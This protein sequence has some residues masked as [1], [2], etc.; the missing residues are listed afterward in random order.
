[1]FH[2]SSSAWPASGEPPLASSRKYR[3]EPPKI[4]QLHVDAIDIPK[5]VLRRDPEIPTEAVQDFAQ[6][7][8]F[9][10]AFPRRIVSV[11]QVHIEGENKLIADPSRIAPRQFDNGEAAS[12]NILVGV[13]GGP[14]AA[15]IGHRQSGGHAYNL[16]YWIAAFLVLDRVL[17]RSVMLPPG[18]ISSVAQFAIEPPYGFE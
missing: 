12:S 2:T 7:V 5:P 10:T 6:L 11:T 17:M 1:M 4:H 8:D 16:L 13:T 15:E 9:G 3:I 18:P 14:P